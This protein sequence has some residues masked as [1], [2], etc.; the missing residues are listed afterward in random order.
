M[1]VKWS[2]P[3]KFAHIFM[4]EHLETLN[5]NYETGGHLLTIYTFALNFK[6]NLEIIINNEQ[7]PFSNYIGS[8]HCWSQK[9]ISWTNKTKLII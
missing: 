4:G 1:Y 6:Y 9:Y 2:I 3:L 7:Q 5:K 8:H